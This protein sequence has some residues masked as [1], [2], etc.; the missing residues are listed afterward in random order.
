M[1][2]VSALVNAA[3]TREIETNTKRVI[4]EVDA[5]YATQLQELKNQNEGMKA[6]VDLITN[7]SAYKTI[8]E[9]MKY[10]AENAKI[11]FAARKKEYEDKI[12]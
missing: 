7:D 4:A 3:V 1:D 2:D 5:K 9:S 11:D 12:N 10:I 8:R 6:Q